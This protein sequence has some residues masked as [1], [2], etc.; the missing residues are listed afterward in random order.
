MKKLAVEQTPSPGPPRQTTLSPNG[1]EGVNSYVFVP[2]A[3]IGGI[4]GED[5]LDLLYKGFFHSFPLDY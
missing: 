3:P 5:H 2:L 1:G 4:G